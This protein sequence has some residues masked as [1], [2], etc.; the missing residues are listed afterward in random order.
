MVLLLVL[1]L[2]LP[3]L[4]QVAID[5]TL[6]W[7]GVPVLERVN[8]LW[9]TLE[10][11]SGV[12]T[13][14]VLEVRAEIGSPWRGRA[15]RGLACPVVLAPGARTTL[16]FP[17]PVLRGTRELS[18]ELLGDYGPVASLSLPVSPA[19]TPLSGTVG[20][21]GQGITL[22]PTDLADPLLLHP[23]GTVSVAVSI[24]PAARSVLLAWA[25][26]LGGDLSGLPAP[27][28]WPWPDREGLV[29]AFAR[30]GLPHPPLA[31]L[32]LAVAAYLFGIG[33]F[34]PPAARG[35]FVIPAASLALA[36]GL[37]LIC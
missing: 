3:G 37:S 32:A 23:F 6:G 18:L 10:N 26:L 20:G 34:L 15:E 33:L 2:A 19:V 11:P 17:W 16:V 4:G 22:S 12:P 25:A 5:A 30:I 1:V 8:P 24:A 7:G 14:G 28:P 9:V 35:R 36:L 21:P 13:A 29:R 27:T 31:P